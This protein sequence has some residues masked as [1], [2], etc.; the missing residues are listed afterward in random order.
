MCQMLY[1]QTAIPH[2]TL[3]E[4]I[5]ILIFQVKKQLREF[6]PMVTRMVEGEPKAPARPSVCQAYSNLLHYS[7]VLVSRIWLEDSLRSSPRPQAGLWRGGALSHSSLL[8]PTGV[9]P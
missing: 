4:V 6:L 9:T 7:A 1:L 5:I 3:T 8:C 2:S